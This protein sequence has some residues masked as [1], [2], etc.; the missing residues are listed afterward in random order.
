MTRMNRLKVVLVEKGMTQKA[1][2]QKL[3]VTPA[4]VNNI[5]NQRQQPSLHKLYLLASVLG[6]SAKDLIYEQIPA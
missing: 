5:C 6:V 2:A 1:L 3:K 4:S